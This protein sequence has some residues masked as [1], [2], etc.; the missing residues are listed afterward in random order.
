MFLFTATM[1]V[2]MLGVS[3][4][5]GLSRGA[6]IRRLKGSARPIQ[7]VASV[8][9]LLVGASLV[10]SAVWTESFQSVFFPG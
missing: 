6:L 7:R 5:V 8:L 4:M 2:L 9:L 10:Y 3:L 1:G